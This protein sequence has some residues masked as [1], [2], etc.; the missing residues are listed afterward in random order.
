MHE[1]DVVLGVIDGVENLLRRQAHVDGVQHRAHHGHGEEAFEIA[2]AVPVHHRHRVAWPDA[3]IG[4]R[5]GETADA[6]SQGRV[7][8]A[9]F[10]GV[11]DLLVRRGGERRVQELADQQRIGIG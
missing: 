5:A 11:D 2:M 9:A 4:E 8:V 3:Q 1:D 7:V 10:V 6:L